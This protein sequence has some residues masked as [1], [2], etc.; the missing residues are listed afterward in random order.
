MDTVIS[1]KKP[2]KNLLTQLQKHAGRNATGKITIRHR[3]G[4]SR[5][6]WRMV[7]FG[8]EYLGVPGKVEALEYDPNRNAFIALVSYQNGKKGY[9]LAS[10]EIKQ[11]DEILCAEKAEVKPGNRMRLSNIPVG[12]LVHNI[13]LEP[14]KGGKIVRSAGSWAQVLA[15]EEN[16]V[17]IQ[18]PSSEIRKV[19]A[20]CFASIGMVSNPEHK[21]QVLGKAGRRRLK[22]WRPAVRGTVMNP[23][24]HP[25]GGGEG[26][27]GRGMKY[28]KTPWGK[29]ALGVKTRNKKR[30]TSKFILSRRKKKKK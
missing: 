23:V 16:F 20:S 3:G 30:W 15:Q 25:H 28:P 1:K 6:M 29:H 22:G 24:D 10:Q 13:E 27:T 19:P 11:G 9:V 4:G 21:Y 12:T 5:K 2:E 26:R 7:D 8:Q 17:N 14:M 18:L